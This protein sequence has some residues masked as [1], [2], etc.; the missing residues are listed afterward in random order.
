MF[1]VFQWHNLYMLKVL[2]NDNQ[3]QSKQ[4]DYV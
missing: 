3:Q 1:T 2:F 4:Y